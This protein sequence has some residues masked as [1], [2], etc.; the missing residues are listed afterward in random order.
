MSA[1]EQLPN[2]I[3]ITFGRA[4]AD[5]EP[6]KVF[7]LA[8]DYEPMVAGVLRNRTIGTTR[9]TLFGDVGAARVELRELCD[10]PRREVLVEEQYLLLS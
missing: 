5:A 8:H 9:Q 6:L 1:V 7:I 2:R 4:P 10:E 3:Q